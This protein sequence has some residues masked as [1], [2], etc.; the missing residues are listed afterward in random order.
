M[1]RYRDE[2][3]VLL[4]EHGTCIVSFVERLFTVANMIGNEI[5]KSLS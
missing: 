5:F 2:V 4:G 3:D 1:M